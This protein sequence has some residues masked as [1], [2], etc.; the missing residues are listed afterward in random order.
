LLKSI[1]HGNALSDDEADIAL[2]A[3][4][5]LCALPYWLYRFLQASSMAFRIG[6]SSATNQSGYRRLFVATTQ[7]VP[8]SASCVPEVIG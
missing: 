3:I 8:S 5:S 4:V 6:A 7:V 2:R 1:L